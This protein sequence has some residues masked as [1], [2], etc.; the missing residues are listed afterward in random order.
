MKFTHIKIEN[1][2]TVGKVEARLDNRGLVLIQGENRDDTSQDSNGAGKSSFVDALSWVLYG[3]TARG[4]SGDTVINSKAGKDCRVS[5]KIESDGTEYSIIRHRKYTKKRNRLEIHDLTHSRE[6]TEGT[7][8]MTQEVVDKLIGASQDVFMASVYAGQERMPDLPGMT[9][10]DLKSIVEEAAGIN[11]VEEA[12]KLA[13]TRM[14]EC[15]RELTELQADLRASHEV[16]SNAESD[17]IDAEINFKDWADNHQPRVDAAATALRSAKSNLD[18]TKAPDQSQF[19]ELQQEATELSE[20]LAGIHDEER[21]RNRLENELKA[22]ENAKAKL[23]ASVEFAVK[24]VH[25]N[26]SYMTEVESKKGEPCGECGRAHDDETLK[27]ALENAKNK[28]RQSAIEAKAINAR[29]EQASEAVKIAS[30]TLLKFKAAMT[31]ASAVL[32][33]QRKIDASERDLKAQQQTAE[34]VK[35]EFTAAAQE[36]KRVKSEENPYEA[37]VNT[38]KSRIETRRQKVDESRAKVSEVESRLEVLKEAVNVFG[39]AGVR[40]HILDTVTPYLNARTAHYMTILSDGNIQVVWNTLGTTSKGELREKFNI[41]ASSITG[42]QTFGLLSGG[43][44]RKVRLACAMA[45]QDLVSSRAS[46]P[47]D[48]FVADEV[49]AAIDVSGLERLMTIMHEKAKEVGTVLVISHSDLKSW[50]SDSVTVVK[51]GGTSSLH[52][53][54]LS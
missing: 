11:Q 39:P 17:L 24:S 28:L 16:L 52:G 23:Q 31:D 43:E 25:Q 1:F 49:D 36:Y 35:R 12:Y 32:S 15:N 2:L 4:E 7:D 45:L 41:D 9:D 47:I 48:L 51:E 40:A 54:A 53:T 6:L 50:I 14:N 22:L 27:T 29:M 3:V 30:E 34:T 19:D 21:E 10:R 46:K 42:G 44:K 5:L 13:R 38:L 33:A 37:V 18:S 20:K 26:K 8:K